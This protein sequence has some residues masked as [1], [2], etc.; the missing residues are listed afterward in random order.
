MQKQNSRWLLLSVAIIILDQA[1]KFVIT[2]HFYYATAHYVTPFF[3]ILHLHNYG[4]AFSFMDYPGGEQRWLLTL[5]S[6]VVSVMFIIWLL[7]LTNHHHW[8]AA[9]LACIIGGALSN[10]CG[11]LMLGYVVDFLDLHMA[12]YHWPAFNVAD[13]AICVGTIILVVSVVKH[14]R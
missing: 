1:T 12:Q 14:K 5:I 3:N 6:L 9:G 13:A 8:F 11:R 4:A 2:Q 7:R 10:L